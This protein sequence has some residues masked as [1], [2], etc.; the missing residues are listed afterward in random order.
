MIFT[1][2][3]AQKISSNLLI[4]MKGESVHEHKLRQQRIY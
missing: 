4:N 1:V 3:K 2:L